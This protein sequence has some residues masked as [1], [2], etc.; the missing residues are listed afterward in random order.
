MLYIYSLHS[1]ISEVDCLLK[2]NIFD[3]FSLNETKLDSTKPI[4]FYKNKDYKIIRR[5]R[6]FD[7]SL[8][9]SG[10][11]GL[12]LFIKKQYKII[13]TFLASK[14]EMI[15]LKIEVNHVQMNI[16][17]VYKSPKTNQVEFVNFLENYLISIDLTFPLVIIGTSLLILML[18]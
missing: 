15:C 2:L 18:T 3:L 10:G 13:S 8:P 6:C 1:K 4:S 11:G 17:S 9:K 12:I 5:D 7:E 16:I 14:Y